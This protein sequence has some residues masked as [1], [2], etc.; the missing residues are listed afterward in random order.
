MKQLWFTYEGRDLT[1][2]VELRNGRATLGGWSTH[3]VWLTKPE[4]FPGAVDEIKIADLYCGDP[5]NLA[6]GYGFRI[7]K[8]A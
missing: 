6:E 2:G 4:Q 5:I 3:E 1:E 8:D 7:E